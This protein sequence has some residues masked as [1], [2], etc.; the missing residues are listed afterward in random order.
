MTAISLG[1]NFCLWNLDDDRTQ[2]DPIIT[3]AMEGEQ[4]NEHLYINIII[5]RNIKMT[6][7]EAS[8]HRSGISWNSEC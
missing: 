3:E 1:V 7:L 2:G 6:A 5:G 4:K 8:A